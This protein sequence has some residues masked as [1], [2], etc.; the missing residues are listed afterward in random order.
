[1][2]VMRILL[3]LI[4][5]IPVNSRY[6]FYHSDIHQTLYPTF[7]CLYAYLVDAGKEVGSRYI[8]NYHLIPYCQRLDTVE[9]LEQV[10]HLFSENIAQTITFNELKKRSITSE[11]LLA[12]FAPIDVAERYEMNN[13]DLDV[14]HN[15]SSPWFGS[16]CQ[17]KFDHDLSLPFGDIVE[18]TSIDHLSVDNNITTGTCYRFL[19]SC[20]RGLWPLCLD[21]REICDGRMDCISGEDEQWCDQLEMTQC[22]NDE[23]RCHHGSQCIPLA[24]AKDSRL[25][26]DCLDGSDEIEEH[27]PYV[28]STNMYCTNVLTFQCQERIGRYPWSFQCGDGEYNSTF[29]IPSRMT[30]CSNERD[31][32]SSRAIL[33]S[34]DH[35]S[36][37]ECRQAFHCALHSNRSQDTGKNTRK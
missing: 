1:M 29:N 18:A 27:L 10:S 28:V 30:V 19:D 22:A 20:N 6:S 3:L 15:C 35:I 25:S 32:E 8:R 14:F 12:W 4:C 23:Y 36:N 5:C 17:Y 2:M 33:T 31:I 34:L 7:D 9:E 21:W 11:Q 37:I 13:S 24:F 26:V 16:I